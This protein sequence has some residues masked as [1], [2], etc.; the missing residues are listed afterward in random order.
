MRC[1]SE[2]K[3]CFQKEKKKRSTPH[4]SNRIELNTKQQSQRKKKKVT[5]NNRKKLKT[6]QL[7]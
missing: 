1:N 7:Q 4:K 6:Q 2:Q 5:Q 3:K